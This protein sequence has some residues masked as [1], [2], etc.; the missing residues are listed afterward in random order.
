M[1]SGNLPWATAWHCLQQCPVNWQ[2]TCLGSLFSLW[3]YFLI[4]QSSP[5]LAHF[6]PTT[7]HS[8]L[9]R[10][11]SVAPSV[12]SIDEHFLKITWTCVM[13]SLQ[14]EIKNPHSTGWLKVT[15]SRPG[16]SSVTHRKKTLVSLCLNLTFIKFIGVIFVNKIIYVSSVD[17]H[18]PWSIT[19]GQIIF[20]HCTLGS[21][22]PPLLCQPPSLWQP[23]HCCLYL[24][25]SFRSTYEQNQMV[26]TFLQLTHFSWHNILK[27]YPCCHNW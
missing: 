5:P 24:N 8:R 17:F 11:S 18:D 9:L 15:C 10:H 7:F 13:K 12:P 16:S 27:F 23:L 6:F 25:F 26:L 2:K 20:P 22:C 1:S 21:F 14:C 3:F 19:Q 4:K